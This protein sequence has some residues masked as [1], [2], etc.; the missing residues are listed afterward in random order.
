MHS[1]A[2]LV[3]D[4]GTVVWYHLLSLRRAQELDAVFTTS[5]LTVAE[6]FGN[7]TDRLEL[8]SLKLLGEQFRS[9]PQD[10]N[11]KMQKKITKKGKDKVN[12]N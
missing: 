1:L 7:L 6:S 10:I 5:A 11:C 9:E 3:P 4:V 2:V 8:E 12:K